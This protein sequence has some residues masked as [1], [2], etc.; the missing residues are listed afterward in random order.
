MNFNDKKANEK[1]VWNCSGADSSRRG[2][3]PKRLKIKTKPIFALQTE[4]TAQASVVFDGD[5]FCYVADM[6]GLIQAFLKDR[7]VWQTKLNGS[8]VASP[9]FCNKPRCIF[10]AT[11]D[12]SLYAISPQNGKILF[13][14]NIPTESDPRILS[15]LLY[16]EKSEVIVLNSWG[17]KFYALNANNLEEKFYW[18][19]GITP[20][21]GASSDSDGNIYCLRAAQGRGVE[22]V[23]ISP[24]AKETVLYREPEGKRGA[25]R[26]IVA[27]APV[28]DETK[29]QIYFIA[30]RDIGSSLCAFSNDALIWKV[31][32]PNQIQ[33]TPTLRADGVLILSDLRGFI[34]GITND[35]SLLFQYNT[36]SDYL[37]AGGVCEQGGTF[38]SGDPLGNV[39][40][41]N[42]RGDGKIIFESSRAILARP[43]FSPNGNLYIPSTDKKIYV[44][45]AQM[46]L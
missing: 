24:N 15:D 14:K 6:G 7:P 11:T 32:L 37:I 30:N 17:G 18:D 8:I 1:F 27:A 19:A 26:T 31:G 21:A 4:A 3:F 45:E 28:I 36:N 16:V 29:K 25:R 13:K 46:A 23:K 42:E 9:V 2:L 20:Y 33:A 39:H 44:F 12:G 43:S 40:Q 22:F 34:L 5:G 10:V 41:I 35:G 38:F